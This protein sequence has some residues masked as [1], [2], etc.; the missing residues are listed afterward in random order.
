[1]TAS[2]KTLRGA[3]ALASM[4][5][6]L[7]LGCGDSTG[8]AK[9]YPVSGTVTYG[10]KPVEKGTISFV[11]AAPGG[12]EA[13]GEISGGSY[14]L[15]TAAPGDGALPGSYKVTVIAKEMDTTKLKEIAK[16]GQFHHD[17]HFAKALKNAKPL[18]PSKYG[19]PE[20]SGLTAEVKAQSNSINFDLTD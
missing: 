9:R 15:T 19:V 5:L 7:V 18:V 10:G 6:F 11:P 14:S 1:M 13:T 20:T 4:G 12:R 16:G 2:S 3:V 8:L 17:E